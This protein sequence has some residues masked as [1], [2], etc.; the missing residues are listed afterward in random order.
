MPNEL[1]LSDVSSPL[2]QTFNITEP[3]GVYLT[4]IGLYFFSKPTVDDGNFPVTLELRPMTEAGLPNAFEVYPGTRVVKSK[5]DVTVNTEFNTASETKFDFPAPFYVPENT[6]VAM[7]LSTNAPP[8]GYRVWIAELGDFEYGSTSKRVI[9]QPNVGVFFISSNGT[10]FTAEQNRDLAFKVYNAQ[11]KQSENLAV[12]YNDAPP[13]RKLSKISP[14]FDDPLIFTA[15]N[16]FVSL[17][18]P[19]HGFQSS[20]Y[21]RIY[22]LDSAETYNGVKGTS[23]LGKR[24][25]TNVD[26]YGFTFR[27]DSAAD[28][29]IRGGGAD[30]LCTQQYVVDQFKLAI[31]EFR[32][33]D[34]TMNIEASMV[35][36]RSWAQN[37]SH[38]DREGLFTLKNGAYYNPELPYVI[39]SADVESDRLGSNPSC[40]FN[41]EMNS[42]NIN[43]AP[44]IDLNSAVLEVGNNIIDYPDSAG[45]FAGAD[46]YD[47]FGY[48]GRNFLSTFDYVSESAILGGSHAAKFMANP[49]LL[50][51]PATS[52]KVLVDAINS[53]YTDFE[54]WYRTNTI[55]RDDDYPTSLQWYKFSTSSI[56]PNSSN[57]DD[58]PRD[59]DRA[60]YREYVFNQQDLPEFNVY[61]IKIVMK[62]TNS[63]YVPQFKNL[64]TIATV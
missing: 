8:G 41:V 45:A 19:Q 36:T 10:N 58:M 21:V 35:T 60:T 16:N 31:P 55:G 43:V 23:I 42:S 56:P 59:N 5:A 26:P 39:A 54:V 64:R 47:S 53:T 48:D 20:D 11:F 2:A 52:I 32:P 25:I 14:L 13:L 49:V 7:T 46:G 28:S 61:Q 17:S 37:T 4:G 33:Q 18:A 57:Y 27:M 50:F 38:Y 34:T 44:Y 6:Q 24:Q 30:M 29:D 51:T 22:G 40:T 62:S 1:N 9:E 15:N 3:G 63:T 12:L